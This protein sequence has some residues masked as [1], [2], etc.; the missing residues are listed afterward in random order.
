MENPG[1]GEQEIEALVERYSDLVYRL[2]FTSTKRQNDAED[3]YQEVFLR[4]IRRQPVFASRE[5]ERAWF[6]RVT[7]NLAHSFWR[8]AWKR[9]IVLFAQDKDFPVSEQEAG[10]DHQLREL[11]AG[12][13]P[14]D[15]NVLHLYYYED[16]SVEQ[17]SR[18]LGV[19]ASTVRTRLTRARRRFAAILEE[20]RK[21]GGE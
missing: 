11:L 7:V 4:Y 14:K 20:E 17:I 21:Y 10:Q 5:H 13:P 16:Y 9:K 18:L 6:I 2:A 8:S 15:R 12:L 1:S 3:L 19:R